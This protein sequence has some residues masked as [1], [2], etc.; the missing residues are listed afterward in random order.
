M[1]CQWHGLVQRHALR[2]VVCS[3]A[4][5]AVIL[6]SLAVPRVAVG[7]DV[8][9]IHAKVAVQIFACGALLCLRFQPIRES[10]S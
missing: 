2:R 6:L 3:G 7:A 9:L 8:W 10:P 5:L 1:P 4:T